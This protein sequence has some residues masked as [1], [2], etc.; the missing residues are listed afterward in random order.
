MESFTAALP[1]ASASV[2]RDGGRASR[3][4]LLLAAVAI[5]LHRHSREEA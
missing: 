5:L 2:V 4:E 1:D 3:H